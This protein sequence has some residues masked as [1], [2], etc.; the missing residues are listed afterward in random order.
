[1]R[2]AD[3]ANAATTAARG[4]GRRLQ[5]AAGLLALALCASSATGAQAQTFP[6]KPVRIVI[7]FT[8]GGP[9]DIVTRPVAQKLTEALGQPFVI[10]YKPGGNAMIGADNVAKSPADGYSLLTFSSGYTINPSTQKSLPYDTLRDLTG[11][12]PIGR[13]HI[14][15]IVNPNLPVRNIRELVALAKKQP[16]KLNFASSGTGGSLH[17]GGELLKV[18]AGIDMTHIAYKGAGPA[19]TDVVA[20]TADLAFIAAPPAVPMIK[21]GKVRLIGVASLERAASFPD[22]PTVAEQGFPKFEVSSGYGLLTRT[23]S[24]AAAI[25]RI[26]AAMKGIVAMDDIKDLFAKASVDPWYLTP[27]ELQGWISD[28][29]EKWQKVTRAI[30]YQPE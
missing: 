25:N 3:M 19:L 1:M 29:V 11:V 8:P 26:N 28:E 15:V 6:V 21:A 12:A 20:G 24:P 16:G 22:T 2:K 17:L 7:A 10:D 30:K 9:I 14:I 4:A 18:V 27:A 5:A 23:G 13:S